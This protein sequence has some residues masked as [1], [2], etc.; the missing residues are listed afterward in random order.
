M[1]LPIAHLAPPLVAE[2]VLNGAAGG[3][4]RRDDRLAYSS[5]MNPAPAGLFLLVNDRRRQIGGFASL[6]VTFS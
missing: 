4:I 2:M 6:S 1:Q 3:L 5:V